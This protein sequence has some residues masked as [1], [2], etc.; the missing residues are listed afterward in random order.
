MKKYLILGLALMISAA[1]F[2]QEATVE[3]ATWSQEFSIAEVEI[4]DEVEIIF[5]APLKPKYHI[6]S[7][8]YDPKFSPT[9]GP[10][11]TEFDYSEV[12]GLKLIGVPKPIDVHIYMDDIFDCEVHEFSN[13]VEF[14]QK[15]RVIGAAPSIKGKVDYQICNDRGCLSYNHK[16]TLAGLKIKKTVKLILEVEDTETTDKTLDKEA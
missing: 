1:V 13:K 3:P 8:N 12:V 10:L 4:G 6:Y 15:A 14:R 16:F 7:N 9:C 2:A 11:L 5:T